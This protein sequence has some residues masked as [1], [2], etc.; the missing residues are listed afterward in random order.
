MVDISN[1][2]TIIESDAC[3]WCGGDNY[4]SDSSLVY[5]W[6][7]LSSEAISLGDDI[8]L[9]GSEATDQIC[10]N[11]VTTC[12]DVACDPTASPFVGETSLYERSYTAGD[13]AVSITEETD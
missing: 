7:G 11:S 9:Y 12:E 8:F 4:D 6:T 13:T 10:L 5:E 2:F 1:D 3:S